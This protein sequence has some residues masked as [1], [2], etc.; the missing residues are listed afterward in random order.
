MDKLN[1]SLQKY[2]AAAFGLLI[3]LKGC[4][5]GLE[6][7]SANR[8]MDKILNQA[9]E[10][11]S[12]YS[13]EYYF[14][15]Y[16]GVSQENSGYYANLI[17]EVDRGCFEDRNEAALLVDIFAR[18]SKKLGYEY[19]YDEALVTYLSVIESTGTISSCVDITMY[20]LES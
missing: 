13:P 7:M 18:R 14:A 12:E 9:D 5:A 16:D 19:S 6:V 3:V 17:D 15:H 20:L 8:K 11:Y 10:I 1:F 2:C 4:N